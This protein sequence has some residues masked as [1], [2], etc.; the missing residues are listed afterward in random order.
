M[1]NISQS[2]IDSTLGAQL[3]N[4]I[5]EDVSIHLSQLGI[6]QQKY[7]SSVSF[8]A[9]LVANAW[10][11]NESSLQ[12]TDYFIDM[13]KKKYVYL[14]MPIIL[15]S[16]RICK[17]FEIET[18][19]GYKV[20]SELIMMCLTESIL[21]FDVEVPLKLLEISQKY[22]YVVKNQEEAGGCSGMILKDLDID[23][24]KVHLIKEIRKHKLWKEDKFW[25]IGVLSLVDTEKKKFILGNCKTESFDKAVEQILTKVAHN[26]VLLGLNHEAIGEKM[27]IF[28]KSY[29]LES[30]TKN[31][32]METINKVEF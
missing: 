24:S 10:L 3:F 22:F 16:F 12:D 13:L 32:I 8:V 25:E 17:I 28:V 6:K 18:E 15:D 14:T 29:K 7:I 31:R 27:K 20:I 1:S 2:T 5:P 30:K 11:G 19:G 9:N 26:M 21:Q 23:D 4:N